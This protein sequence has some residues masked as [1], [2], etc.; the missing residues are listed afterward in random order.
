M[1]LPS[2]A[3][4]AT[5]ARDKSWDVQPL[6]DDARVAVILLVLAT[7]LALALVGLV[8]YNLLGSFDFPKG[9]LLLACV[10]FPLGRLFLPGYWGHAIGAGLLLLGPWQR[11]TAGNAVPF[12]LFPFL[13]AGA[14][15]ALLFA[16]V[17]LADRIGMGGFLVQY[18]AR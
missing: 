11:Y 12:L 13:L 2:W 7:A 15:E 3:A 9:V 5:A 8:L 14:N 10:A 18:Y 16:F 1:S 6:I 17:K 4:A